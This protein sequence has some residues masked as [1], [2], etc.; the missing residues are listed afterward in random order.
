[1]IS[2]NE[3]R[4]L[5]HPNA[6]LI[7]A[8]KCGTT[9]IASYLSDHP[10]VFLPY[11]K[12]PSFWSFDLK[13]GAAVLKLDGV[14]DYLR[15]YETAL[16]SHKVLLD[17]STSYL[18]SE[19]A[20]QEILKFSPDAKFVVMLRNPVDVAY[21]FHM[22]QLFNTFEDEESF[23]K[24]WNLQ[25]VRKIGKMIPSRCVEPKNLQY[26]QVAALGSHLTRLKGLLSEDQLHIIFY[27]D[28]VENPR[29]TYLSLLS[30][31]SLN[32]D[33]RENFEITGSAHYNKYPWL[34][35]FYQNPS[36]RIGFLVRRIKRLLRV[37]APRNILEW[38]KN[39]MIRRTPR[40]KLDVA[41]RAMLVKEFEPEVLKI[42][43]ITGRDLS[44]W[45]I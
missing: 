32:D 9:A 8:P 25:D 1:M 17:A 3:Y 36:R 4:K 21:A 19:N 29:A 15:L 11:P 5:K 37:Y 16:F 10:N 12:E 7:G 23:E 45:R 26:R 41:F 35:A 24:A 22:E 31:L 20:V 18:Q 43:T 39:L 34:A 27:E 6:F 14:E 2:E 42:E 33:G 40:P 13:R 38:V 28:F 44:G 30:F